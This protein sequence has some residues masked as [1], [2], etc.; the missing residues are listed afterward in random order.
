MIHWALEN[1]WIRN[2][3]SPP[4][5][6]SYVLP[7]PNVALQGITTQSSTN[8]YIGSSRNAND[9]S[10][11]NNYLRAQC[12]VTQKEEHPWWMVDL[13]KRHRIFSVAI[14]NRVLEC[15]KERI[16][17]AEIRIGNN[18]EEGGKLNPKCGVI[19]S[20]ES[21][22]TI[23]FSC[24]GMI[25]QY[26]SVVLPGKED[27]LV[28]CEVQVFGLPV[29]TLDAVEEKEP[30]DLKTPNGAP[31]VAVNGIA[32]QSSLYNMYGEPKNA[33]DGS[34]NSNYLFI[35]CA[36]T[37]EQ[38]NP[39][40]MVDLK[41]R[42]KIFTVAITNRGDCC[43]NR[44]NKAQIRIGNSEEEGGTHNPICGVIRTM[45]N[46]ETL[47]FE[48]NGMEGQYVTV[49]LP[50][51][52]KSITICEVQVFGLPVIAEEPVK[53]VPEKEP[54][55]VDSDEDIFKE[56]LELLE[57][58]DDD[59]DGDD[60]IEYG[61]NIAFR[62]ISSQ[63]STYDKFGNANNAIDGSTSKQYMSGHCSHTDLDIEPWWRVDLTD[64]F[65]VTVVRITNRGDCCKERINGA[66]IRIGMM[67]EN[68]GTKNP[69]CAKIESMSLGE[70]QTFH[71]AMVGRYVTITIPGKAAYLTLCEVKVYGHEV[72]GNY[73]GIS[74]SPHSGES[75]ESEATHLKYLLKHSNAAPNVA[76]QGI[77]YQS[78]TDE[79]GESKNAADGSLE[80]NN[81]A[82]QCAK[83]N[84]EA[85]PWWTV[86]L[87]SDHKVFSIAVTNRGDCCD[88][89]LNGAEIHVG[90]SASGWK[91]NP[92]CGTIKS[93]GLGE[94]FSFNCH[95]ME[96]R[97]VTIALPGS[98]KSLT[99]CEVQVFGLPVG[100]P[101]GE[102]TGNIEQHKQYHGA[103]NVAPQGVPS[104]S[105]YYG[106]R[107]SAR[108]AIDGS[109]SSSYMEGQCTHTEKQLQP[110]WQLDLKSK[111]KVYSVAITNRGDCC[112]ERINGAEIHIGDSEENGGIG[113][114]RC[115]T[116]FKMGYGETI[117][118]D[119]KGMEGRYVTVTI[120]D[121]NGF[122]TLCEVQVFADP[123]EAAE[124]GT[125][126][127]HPDPEIDGTV[128]PH[129]D[130]EI[131]GTVAPHPEQ[132][133]SGE[134][135][136]SVPKN[137]TG[138]AFFF[139]K[140]NDDSYV[141][142][143]PMKPMDLKS[144]TLC[145]KL[146]LD[147]PKNRE[148][149]LFSYRTTYFD[150]LNLWLEEDRNIGFY[151][152]GDGVLFPPIDITKEWNHLCLT[153]ESRNGRCELWVNGRRSATKVYRKK[154]TVH[155]KGISLLGQ[156]QDGELHGFDKSQ[157]YVGKIQELNMWD[158]VLSLKSLKSLFKDKE[159]RKGNIFDW[160][161]LSF[162]V[163]G[164]VTLV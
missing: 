20:I 161:S 28:L 42:Y 71:C 13:R 101:G 22:E 35:E 39:W 55:R 97:Y 149:I 155:S 152:R 56:F 105:S 134:H 151:M 98:T 7:A 121:V 70:E 86:D 128:A 18:H 122:L 66:E 139:P 158:K 14:T 41:S 156:D 45:N 63:S 100:T 10:L 44:I 150:E 57:A 99:L 111:M 95:G 133:T 109:L 59:D 108:R 69:R 78:S 92:I 15:C 3:W 4:Q 24:Q 36:G 130:P 145:M 68:G 27:H 40:W 154:H 153:W 107:S 163:K 127:P 38:D 132:E 72:S 118:Y 29:S 50:G 73:T 25:G 102:W 87:K 51:S 49:F 143:S 125:V 46:G 91:K 21:G 1:P 84:E 137:L 148:T 64:T 47:A 37:F 144:F 81:P 11:A 31:N 116:I 6:G 135:E 106:T 65:N 113:N 90:Q 83:T 126:A 164:N 160:E 43:A 96:G 82:I 30:K 62:G 162:T 120:P 34:L 75:E 147:V 104:Q 80:N 32:R 79:K 9:G 2:A 89:D 85:D 88:Q 141:Y 19:S 67:P 115:A 8:S 77:T 58:V 119:C 157:S 114:P 159:I 16:Y 93:I 61:T 17:G 138:K 94:T 12:S 129:P 53:E 54:E 112:R 131:D 23:S 146:S 33:I 48:C 140:E 60:D 142:L 74:I 5:D 26:V 136:F 110:W 117:S 52:K 103:K 76:L 123:L 124:D